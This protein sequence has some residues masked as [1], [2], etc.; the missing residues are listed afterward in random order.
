MSRRQTSAVTAA[1]L[2]IAAGAAACGVSA[3]DTKQS[4]SS[5][6][7]AATECPRGTRTLPPDAVAGATRSALAQAPRVF[8]G[9][10]LKGMRVISAATSAAAAGSATRYAR[11]KCGPR[12][13]RRTVAVSLEFPAM[14]PSASLSQGT[15]LV[16]PTRSAYVVWAR[17]H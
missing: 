2:S 5:A 7:R 4:A 12:I 8:R 16:S 15:V 14:K 17:L 11:T 13:Q 10:K 3:N 1:V 6:Q 9:T